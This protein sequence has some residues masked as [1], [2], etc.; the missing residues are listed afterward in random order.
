[1]RPPELELPPP[2]ED[3]GLVGKGKKAAT[4]SNIS[5]AVSTLSTA[6]KFYDASKQKGKMNKAKAFYEASKTSSATS[7]SGTDYVRHQ[8]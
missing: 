4:A 3:T 1:M 8:S 6:K 2:A 7:S 5:S